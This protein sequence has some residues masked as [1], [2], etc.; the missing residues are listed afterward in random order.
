MYRHSCSVKV[1]LNLPFKL[2]SC[3]ILLNETL[4]SH[5]PFVHLGVRPEKWTLKTVIKGNFCLKAVECVW[6]GE[7]V[8]SRL[9]RERRGVFFFLR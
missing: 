9:K 8:E 4:E 6:R 2:V 7:F 1:N 3:A 5:Q